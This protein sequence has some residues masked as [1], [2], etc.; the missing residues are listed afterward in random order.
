MDL[1]TDKQRKKN[2]LY[3]TVFFI[4]L[5]IYH[6]AI[7]IDFG[8][9]TYYAHALDQT[10]LAAFLINRY[11][12]WSSRLVIE[13]LLVCFVRSPLLWKVA[14]IAVM[15]LLAFA[16]YELSHKTSLFL[17]LS[18]LLIY[19][20]VEMNTAGWIA[21]TMN[22]LW[23]LAFGLYSLLIIDKISRHIR[24]KW[25]ESLLSIFALIIGANVEQ[26]CAV[27]IVILTI[28]AIRIFI[29]KNRDSSLW[30]LAVHYLIS[31]ASL[32]FVLTCPGNKLRTASEVVSHMK[33]FYQKTLIDKLIDGFENTMA[34]MLSSYNLIF[35]IFAIF[36]CICVFK[37]T[38]SKGLRIVALIPALLCPV[39]QVA[40]LLSRLKG[41]DFFMTASLL[42]G[43][44]GATAVNWPHAISYVPFVAFGIII[45]CMLV[46]VFVVFEDLFSSIEGIIL[47]GIGLASRVIMG[48]SPTIVPSG[49]RTFL[50]CYAL[51]VLII[52]KIYGQTEKMFSKRE[53]QAGR[54]ILG[55]VAICMVAFDVL[56]I[57]FRSF[58]AIVAAII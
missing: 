3:C 17:V 51:I 45:C 42:T 13:A 29:D 10:G 34:G 12:T 18:M 27:H 48:F 9:D 14:D 11:Y 41:A 53:K 23:P 16:L 46:S 36:L 7:R 37:R 40:A 15:C 33:D 4:V 35:L 25:W 30:I 32:L 47:F 6:L 26:Y 31:F 5:V 28:Y 8:D 21:T 44:G 55:F 58:D 38:K 43:D 57:I 1:L 22:Y 49:N 24:P 52:L 54:F 56:K 19:P 50:F 2:I 39:I 20:F